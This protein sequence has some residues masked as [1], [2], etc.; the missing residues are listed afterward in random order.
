[1]RVWTTCVGC[2]EMP[3]EVGSPQPPCHQQHQELQRCRHPAL[4]SL[5]QLREVW[6]MRPRTL[7]MPP[8]RMGVDS[9]GVSVEQ[10]SM[11]HLPPAERPIPMLVLQGDL[12]LLQTVLLRAQAEY[13]MAAA[14]SCAHWDLAE[15]QGQKSCHPQCCD[16]EI[17]HLHSLC[18]CLHCDCATGALEV[19]HCYQMA[20]QGEPCMQPEVIHF[21]NGQ[22]DSCPDHAELERREKAGLQADLYGL[23]LRRPIPG[24]CELHDE[25]ARWGQ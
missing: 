15:N 20:C 19:Q 4:Q 8:L 16:P 9:W 17:A 3:K 12:Q 2:Q 1:M 10:G 11:Q 18:I 21:C 14:D 25:H 5:D 6:V 23:Q 22:H 7:V 24:H 13:G